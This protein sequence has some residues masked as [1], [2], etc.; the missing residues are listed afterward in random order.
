[1]NT[2]IKTWVGTVIIIIIAI[3]TIVFVWIY[4]KNQNDGQNNSCKKM[5][6]VCGS[7]N[8]GCRWECQDNFAPTN[9]STSK[10]IAPANNSVTDE[11]SDLA[12]SEVEGWQ[13]YRNDKY[14]FEFQY[15]KEWKLS[16]P[17]LDG[18]SLY[19]ISP[20]TKKKIEEIGEYPS[21][22]IMIFYYKSVACME[23]GCTNPAKNLLD[24]LQSYKASGIIED[25]KSVN[26]NGING[27]E[28]VQLGMAGYY[29]L[30]LE[31]SKG[32]YQI[33]FNLRA[34]KS[35]LTSIENQILSTFKFTN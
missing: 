20:D 14:G 31:N 32:I 3:T 1:M 2:K 23:L 7:G 25:I 16:L 11:T 27:Y 24:N 9:A 6:Q 17:E 15:P 12:P 4:E 34:D 8:V 5:M 35:E 29:T 30:Y 22:D 33:E 19:L 26:I 10:P 13:T 28:A 21:A 18:F